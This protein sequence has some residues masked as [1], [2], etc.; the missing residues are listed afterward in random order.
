M[1]V[2][3]VDSEVLEMKM[4]CMRLARNLG[5]ILD[6]YQ[7]YTAKLVDDSV[8]EGAASS[9]LVTVVQVFDTHITKLVEFYI[10]C[11]QYLN[12]VWEEMV[13]LDAELASQ[14][15]FDY[16]QENR[17]LH[18]EEIDAIREVYGIEL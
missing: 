15:Y 14:M 18:Q 6:D 9:N 2:I 8:Y 7:M 16:L 17:E 10:A 4:S 3:S 5:E 11:A 1:A 13:K 12:N